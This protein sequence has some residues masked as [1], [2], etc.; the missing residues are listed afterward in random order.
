MTRFAL[1]ALLLVG[2]TATP[3]P[4]SPH[5]P[6]P[7]ADRGP[8]AMPKEMTQV[9]L[10]RRLA[11]GELK[12]MELEPIERR[13]VS[14]GGD[15]AARPAPPDELVTSSAL[16]GGWSS[17]I[18]VDRYRRLWVATQQHAVHAPEGVIISATRVF[19]TRWKVPVSYRVVGAFA[20][21]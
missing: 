12:V 3:P 17:T 13:E 19:E 21:R 6:A 15:D 4:A 9:E 14:V 10:E 16:P 1:V 2:C 5:D 18:Y 8:P 20:V 7:V 11:S